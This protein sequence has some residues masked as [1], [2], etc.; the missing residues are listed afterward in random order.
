MSYYGFRPYV[1]VAKRREK[2]LKEARK[3]QKAGKDLTPVHVEGR[4][5]AK[6]VWGQAW[7]DN[8]ESYSDYENRLPRGRTYVRNGSVIDLAIEP[9]KVRAQVMGSSLYRIEITV[10]PAAKERWER[11]VAGVTGSIASLVELLQGKLSKG[12]MEKICHPDSGLFPSPKEIALS[13]S[14]PDWAS[15]CKHVAA[16]LYGVGARLDDSPELLFTLRNVAASDLIVEAAKVPSGS[17]KSPSKGR[18][19]EAEGLDELFG[20]ELEKDAEETPTVPRRKAGRPAKGE[21]PRLPKKTALPRKSAEGASLSGKERKT[22]KKSPPG[23]KAS[24]RPLGKIVPAESPARGKAPARSSKEKEIAGAKKAK[25]A[26]NK[27]GTPV[28]KAVAPSGTSHQKLTP[29]SATRRSVQETPVKA[30]RGRPPGKSSTIRT[31][32]PKKKT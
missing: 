23:T 6:T 20:I 24:A 29:S 27:T 21:S 17:K 31:S 15:M 5:I 25:V 10:A 2:A 14:C 16:A 8:L 11:L 1:P 32:P 9:G 7:C 26:E 18:A 19:L 22:A 13:C 12:V 30:R 3:N 4:K 28:K